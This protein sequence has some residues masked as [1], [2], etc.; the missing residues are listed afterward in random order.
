MLRA[1]SGGGS[2][3]PGIGWVVSNGPPSDAD[4][5]P[6][7]TLA[8]DSSSTTQAYYKKV[9]GTY[10]VN[11]VGPIG[12]LQG[13][14]A[15]QTAAS[16]V[17]LGSGAPDPTVGSAGQMYVDQSSKL[18]YLP[19][20]VASITP[21]GFFGVNIHIGYTSSFWPNMTV[22]SYLAL[23]AQMGIQTVRTNIA[24]VAKANNVLST[25]KGLIAGGIDVLV[26][27][28]ASPNLGSTFA[29][30]QSAASTLGASLAT[31]LMGSGVKYIETSNEF[32]FNCK[33]NGSNPRG[34]VADGGSY[35]DF[36]SSKFECWRGWTSGMLSGIRG[37]TS[38]FK[39]GYASGVAFPQ[40]AFRMLREGRDT[41]GAVTQ[42]PLAFDFLGA[43][44]Y[45]TQGNPTSF[46][47]KSRTGSPVST[48][49]LAELRGLTGNVTYDVPQTPAFELMVTEWGS[50]A[51]DTNQGS[52]Y[53]QR[54]LDF[55]NW[56]STYNIKAIYAY[57]LF[58]DTTDAGTG[59][60]FGVNALNFGLI[61]AD[62]STKKPAYNSFCNVIQSNTVTTPG[63]WPAIA[64]A[65]PLPVLG[66]GAQVLAPL[67]TTD[68]T[69]RSYTIPGGSMGPNTTLRV[70]AL[71][72]CPTN[73]NTKTFRVK[74]GGN[75]IYQAGF[76][77][78]TITV[79][80]E[81]ILQNRG[82]LNAQVGQ[83]VALLGPTFTA[84]PIQ[85]WAIDTTVDQVVAFTAQAGVGTDQLTLERCSI[86]L[87]G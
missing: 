52:F 16:S 77:S 75:V 14:G 70:T 67:N 6:D 22:T 4:G 35:D 53:A 87:I 33:I 36:T 42:T 38:E 8:L 54:T 9:S 12:T 5:N 56:K 58:A 24:S 69:L 28:D 51:A 10:G 76:T 81:V 1:V 17:I 23:F 49:S 27:I 68:N 83:P 30:Q 11:T 61:Q 65:L 82:V 21:V 86:E 15:G 26:V 72:T 84:G 71:F 7:G 2:S 34:F 48:N 18:V 32:D 46:T 80:I 43:H 63:G 13:A 62:G 79:N 74:W 29:A 78:T 44:F 55:F 40:T 25:V 3:T 59:P 64:R 50:R 41:T 60:V 73:A 66:S 85:T 47:C 37:V 31:A 45:D 57:A 39:L 20:G 19:K